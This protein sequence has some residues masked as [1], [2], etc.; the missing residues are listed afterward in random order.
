[1]GLRKNWILQYSLSRGDAAAAGDSAN[2]EAPWPYSI[3]RP[4]IAPGSI[5][6]DALIIHGFV[7]QAGRFEALSVAFP[8]EFPQ[9]QFVLSSLAQWKFRPATQNGQNIKVEVLLVIPEEP[10]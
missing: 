7:N 6:A 3:V 1:V 8:P 4:N 2:I 5:D 10:E 9:A